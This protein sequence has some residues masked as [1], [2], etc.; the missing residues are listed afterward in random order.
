MGYKVVQANS[1]AALNTLIAAEILAGNSPVGEPA[2]FLSQD[3]PEKVTLF[4]AVITGVSTE[5]AY[6]V[7]QASTPGALATAVE[8][9]L[10]GGAHVLGGVLVVRSAQNPS[11]A[12]YMQATYGG[13]APSAGE[14]TAGAQ[15]AT[16]AGGAQGATGAQ[17]PQGAQGAQGPQGP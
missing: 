12:I 8:A 2:A 4:Q 1:A 3:Y 7:Y 5:S 17:G 16:G 15:G 13:V 6:T 10:T 9:A 11:T 14:G